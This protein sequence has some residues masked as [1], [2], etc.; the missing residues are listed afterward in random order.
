MTV[1]KKEV[2]KSVQYI[3][4]RIKKSY[5]TPNTKQKQKKGSSL[6]NKFSGKQ[7]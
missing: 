6:E 3:Y 5:Q 1:F 2:L 7:K 4:L